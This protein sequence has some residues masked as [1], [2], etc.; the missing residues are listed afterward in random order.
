MKNS[1]LLIVLLLLINISCNTEK[2]VPV[3][4]V[5]Y[6]IESN[7]LLDGISDDNAWGKS[8]TLQDF[9]FPWDDKTPPVTIFRALYDSTALYFFYKAVDQSLVI[10]DSLNNEMDIAF[11][12]RVE[13]YLS[14][15]NT[16]KEY[17][18]FE[19][20]PLGRVL[21]Y[22]AS[23]YRILDDQ[24]NVDG[25]QVASRIDSGSYQIEVAIPLNSLAEMGIDIS[26]DFY[27]GLFRAEFENSIS[28]IK[29]NWLSWINPGISK[30][31]FHVPEALG[32]FRF[33]KNH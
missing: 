19:I 21:D 33:K 6:C 22:K 17:F 4:E 28:G 31:D 32:I 26:K 12:D 24:W 8:I 9:I 14:K 10:K 15:D 11:E 2:K 29:E 18:C 23:Y 7:I 5:N 25:I 13:L 1:I 27:A 30:P 20:D 3:Y 16:M